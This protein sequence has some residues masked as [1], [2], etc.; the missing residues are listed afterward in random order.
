MLD[1]CINFSAEERQAGTEAD[2][3]MMAM[4]H[5]KGEGLDWQTLRGPIAT[6]IEV[7][8]YFIA[9]HWLS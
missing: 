4:L 9:L 8:T 7:V 2:E 6:F 5:E 1:L 3:R